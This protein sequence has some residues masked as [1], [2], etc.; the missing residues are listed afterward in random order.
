MASNQRAI[1]ARTV[2][3]LASGGLSVAVYYVVFYILSEQLKVWYIAS[4][5]GAF[6]LYW[7]TNFGLHKYWTFGDK[8]TEKIHSQAGRHLAMAVGMLTTNTL[9]LYLLVE[10]LGLWHMTA[11]VILTILLSATSYLLLHKIFRTA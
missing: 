6:I 9:G 3:F 2:R 1:A 8:N 7:L 10:K 5:L 4:S 11:Q